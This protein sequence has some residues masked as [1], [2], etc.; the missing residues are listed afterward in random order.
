MG[1]LYAAATLTFY[2]KICMS[3]SFIQPF[4]HANLC[5]SPIIYYVGS[6]FM[7]VCIHRIG[8]LYA[9]FGFYVLHKVR[10]A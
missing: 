4:G 1:M 6:E 7:C 8:I 3:S 9:L 10:R 2:L 5:I